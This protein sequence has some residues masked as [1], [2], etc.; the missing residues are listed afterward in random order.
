M[1]RADQDRIAQV[2]YNLVDNAVKF[3]KDNGRLTI[4]TT[5]V[6]DK[7]SVTVDNDG[8]PISE[9]DKPHIFDR[10]YKAD[11]AH[12]SG[13]GTGLGLSICKKIMDMHGQPIRM[14]PRENGAAFEILLQAGENP[15]RAEA[16]VGEE[17]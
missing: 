6:H 9:A 14:L 7:V 1:V 10:F 17:S 2:I 15:Q 8:I 4:S 3:A 16:L 13:R 12:T 5:L 11:K